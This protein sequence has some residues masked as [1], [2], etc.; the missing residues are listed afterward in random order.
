MSLEKQSV[1]AFGGLVTFV[2]VAIR[3]ERA[4]AEINSKEGGN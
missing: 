3:R 2:S 1:S 4:E